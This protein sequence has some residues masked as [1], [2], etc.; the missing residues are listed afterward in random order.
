[1]Y[2]PVLMNFFIKKSNART[3]V[4][5]NVA[6]QDREGPVILS[7]AKNL[8]WQAEILRCAQNDSPDL[9][10]NIHQDGG[11]RIIV[12]DCQHSAGCLART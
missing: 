6:N 7:A 4:P 10:A 1:M 9:V 3:S 8:A 11:T 2:M 12:F 5:M